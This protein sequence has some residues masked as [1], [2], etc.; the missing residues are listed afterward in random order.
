MID[1]F[2]NISPAPYEQISNRAYFSRT[3]VAT[4]KRAWQDL[5]AQISKLNSEMYNDFAD[6]SKDP[7]AILENRKRLIALEDRLKEI[8]SQF[9]EHL[10]QIGSSRL[11]E[12]EKNEIR[13]LYASRLYSQQQLAN[14]YNVSQPTISDIVN[15]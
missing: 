9:N 11:T 14:Q 7:V 10:P 2:N 4:T 13:C 15:A 1:N 6:R 12:A 8:E 5:T 3:D